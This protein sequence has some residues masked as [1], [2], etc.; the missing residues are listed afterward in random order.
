MKRRAGSRPFD[1]VRR[2]GDEAHATDRELGAEPRSSRCGEVVDRDAVSIGAIRTGCNTLYD[3]AIEG[4][5]ER[6]RAAVESDRVTVERLRARGQ[7]SDASA[8]RSRFRRGAIR[9]R[10]SQLARRDSGVREG[11]G[12]AAVECAALI[13]HTL[14]PAGHQ[15]GLPQARSRRLRLPGSMSRTCC[16]SQS[17]GR[18]TPLRLAIVTIIY[19]VI[20]SLL[21]HRLVAAACGPREALGKPEVGGAYRAHGFGFVVG[22][23]HAGALLDAPAF[24]GSDTC[25]PAPCACSQRRRISSPCHLRA[26][27]RNSPARR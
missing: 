18:I 7:A 17:T 10:R 11:E 2:L 1:T 16:T 6:H 14:R 24:F 26:A 22:R 21:R 9:P 4:V 15:L 8:I 23:V 3:S 20:W 12:G 13:T 27:A 19:G 25:D 5:K